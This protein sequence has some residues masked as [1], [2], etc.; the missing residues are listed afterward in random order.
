MINSRLPPQALLDGIRHVAA[1][2]HWFSAE[3]GKKMGDEGRRSYLGRKL[4][5]IMSELG[6][7]VSHRESRVT[8]GGYRLIYVVAHRGAVQLEFTDSLGDKTDLR[9]LESVQ[10]YQTGEWEQ[11]ANAVYQECLDLSN[12]WNS[13]SRLI[14]Q[15][16]SASHAPEEIIRLIEAAGDTK[17]VIKLLVLSDEWESMAGVLNMAYALLGKCQESRLV[18]DTI[19]STYPENPHGYLLLGCLFRAALQNANPPPRDS[20]ARFRELLETTGKAGEEML[21]EIK[22]SNPHLYRAL[23]DREYER[24]NEEIT[25]MLSRVTLE[26]LGC[27]WDFAYNKAEELFRE[28][29]RMSRDKEIRERAKSD[30]SSLRMY[31]KPE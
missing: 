25:D 2:D 23:S 30:L 21:G 6:I 17:E 24:R 12:Q 20:L 5:S 4:R 22:V 31:H 1:W 9:T 3:V 7:E 15:L 29:M 28:A 16:G 11:K 10:T 26:A 18:L 13:V 8:S 27:S 19:I 14:E